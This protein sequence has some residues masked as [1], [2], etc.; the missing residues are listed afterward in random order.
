MYSRFQSAAGLLVSVFASVLLLA[1]A[2]SL[3]GCG[4]GDTPPPPAAN[5]PTDTATVGSSGGQLAHADGVKLSVP[6]GALSET[7]TLHVAKDTTGMNAAL[8]GV[9]A[10]PSQSVDLSPTYALTPHGTRFA[11]PVELRIPLNAATATGPGSLAVLRTEPGQGHWELM[12]VDKVEGGAAVVAIDGFSFYKVVRL[13]QMPL[14]TLNAPPAPFLID[15]AASFDG[16]GP[17]T[18]TIPSTTFPN[19]QHRR[20]YG[21]IT[22]RTQNLHYAAHIVGLPASCASISLNGQAR[23]PKSAR[24]ED[25][26]GGTLGTGYAQEPAFAQTTATSGTTTVN[27]HSYPTLDFAFDLN[28]ANAPYQRSVFEALRA[29]NNTGATPTVAVSFNAWASCS[30]PVD[31]GG[32]NLI[33]TW[34]VAP[35]YELVHDT[36]FNTDLL[37]D[38]GWVWNTVQYKVDYLPQGFITHPAD[39]TVAAGA[40]ASFATSAWPT[41]VGEQRI[42]WWR[43]NNEG[44]SWTRVRTSLVPVS[45]T[46]DTL[47]LP[48]VVNADH[49]ALFRA[50]L[51]TVPRQ[52]SVAETC[53]DGLAARLPVIQGVAAASFVQQPRAVLVRTGQTAS[54]SVQVAGTP[55]PTLRWQSRPANSSAAWADVASGTGAT[56][57]NYSTAALVPADNG[58][59]LR[60]VASNLAGE[61]ASVPVTVSVSDQD[62]APSLLTQP[63]SISVVAGSEAVFAVV[64]RGTEALSYQWRRNGQPISGANAPLLKLS[65]VGNSDA[66]VYSVQVSNAVGTVISADATLQ[67]S[68]GVAPAVAPSV[69]TAPAAVQVGSGNTVT[70]AVGAAGTGPLGYQWLKNGQPVAGA[71]AAFHSFTAAAGDNGSSYSVVVSNSAGSATSAA[72]QLTVL[73]EATPTA[74]S[75]STQPS[76]QVQLPGGIATFAVAASGTGPLTY[77]WLKDGTAMPSATDAVLQLNGVSSNDAASYSV[78]VSNALGSLTSTAASLTV[79]GAPAISTQPVSAS[80]TAGNTASFSVAATGGSLR[81][82]WTRNHLAIAGATGA[83]YTTPA[84]NVGDSG[85][86]YG[87]I[88]FNGAGLV[89]SSDATVTVT[90][91]ATP[92][93][94]TA[95]TAGFGSSY[96]VDTLGDVWAWGYLVDPTTGGYKASSPW[97]SAPVRV[98]GLFNVQSVVVVSETGNAYA[99]HTDG[100]VSAWGRNEVGQLGDQTTTTRNLPVKVLDG[101]DWAD[102]PPITGICQIA[103]GNAALAMAPCDGSPVQMVGLMSTYNFG[104]ATGAGLTPNGGVAKAVPGLPSGTVVAMAMPDAAANAEGGLLVSY[105]DGR[106]FAWGAQRNNSL[107]AGAAETRAG[108]AVAALDVT[109]T[110]GPN[111]NHVNK[112]EM[113]RDFTLVRW[114]GGAVQG[115]GRNVEGQLGNGTTNT[116]TTLDYVGGAV[117]V[118]QFSVGQVNAAALVNGNVWVWGWH[119]GSIKASPTQLTTGGGFAQLSLGDQHG[120]LIDIAGRVQA[121]GDGSYGAL[122]TGASSASQP[123]V[124]MRP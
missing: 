30:T 88:V 76:A 20:L 52:A 65:G 32:G 17:E 46:A 14:A 50:R 3:T 83:S 81:Y 56:S 15:I 42:E 43:S 104:G 112:I 45:D 7:L 73:A 71:T 26:N 77:Q 64:A 61:V 23:F 2:L 66:S 106:V 105:S 101:G 18:F 119:N 110:F 5:E 13:V 92:L 118:G 24:A 39:V 6:A 29:A 115:L 57:A 49:N 9:A 68:A 11:E 59:Q 70:F 33:G 116:R 41:P 28:M 85:A 80:V 102:P 89:I 8:L 25:A 53:T 121:W 84:L 113:G 67:V 31:M 111:G 62:V 69:V 1:L 75:I 55:A 98:Q 22:T 91:A 63:A 107:G 108:T 51:C 27:G 16:V 12:P 96:A 35:G 123:V 82:Q 103:A 109:A 79:V 37:D 93:V 87:V 99:L 47:T 10:D 97:A 72:A 117:S 122:G 94:A 124:V 60:A 90:A 4:G 34:K 48:S 86:S 74:V 19:N 58:L 95:V 21:E 40:S 54:L 44:A 38:K 120:L 100:T 114:S 78:T 36:F